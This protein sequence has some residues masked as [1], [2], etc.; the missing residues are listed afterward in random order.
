M[1]DPAHSRVDSRRGAVRQPLRTYDGQNHALAFCVEHDRKRAFLP[2][3]RGLN[4]CLYAQELTS[5]L[6]G[7]HD[8]Q[9]DSASQAL[10]SAKQY[11]SRLPMEEFRERQL[12]RWKLGLSDD[13]V[14][15]Q[16]EEDD[17]IIAEHYCGERIR[18]SGEF[19]VISRRL[20]AAELPPR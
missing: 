10:D 19:W 16:C 17:E 9:A 1:A 6:K 13:F 11:P 15:M 20:S 2:G 5:F 3:G 7:K 12:L 18:W 14:F 4:G 8:D